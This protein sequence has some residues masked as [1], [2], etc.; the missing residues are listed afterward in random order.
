MFSHALPTPLPIPDAD[1]AGA[2]DCV[3]I[4]DARTIND[5]N[6][7]LNITHTWVGDLVV[8][9][10]HRNTGRTATLLERPGT[11]FGPLG[12]PRADIDAT[13]DDEA[14]LPVDSACDPGTPT[15]SGTLRPHEPLTRF[16]GE[17]LS[18]VWSLHVI[19]EAPGDVGSLNS[20]SL[21]VNAPGSGVTP[22]PTRTAGLR[23]DVNCDGVVD[24]VDAALI[25]QFVAGLTS[26]LP[27]QGRADVN[28]DGTI[29]SIDAA[30]VLQAVAGLLGSLPP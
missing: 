12:C 2:S 16:D 26:P 10:T 11:Q 1:P 17:T 20:W 27:C 25:L 21:V 23:G 19:D 4:E 9:L 15:I 3:I 29:S 6:V 5:L 22:T 30:L 13:L 18:G 28:G 24:S 8:T 14:A 7:S